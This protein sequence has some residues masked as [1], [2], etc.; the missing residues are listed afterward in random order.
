MNEPKTINHDAIPLIDERARANRA[1]A[2]AVGANRK[3]KGAN[4]RKP[5][6]FMSRRR[7]QAKHKLRL[8]RRR[9]NPTRKLT[10]ADISTVNRGSFGRERIL[11][12]CQLPKPAF[13]RERWLPTTFADAAAQHAGPA[14]STRQF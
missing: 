12:R 14:F 9:E 3:R 13:P 2:D 7:S 11:T 1:Y 5:S 4:D 6:A 8:T 10:F